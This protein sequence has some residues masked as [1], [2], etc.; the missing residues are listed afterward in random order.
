VPSPNS[1]RSQESKSRV[2]PAPLR[3]LGAL[4]VP[5]WAARRHGTGAGHAAQPS[6]SG[7]DGIPPGE[8]VRRYQGASPRHMMAPPCRCLCIKCPCTGAG[9]RV[10]GALER[11]GPRSRPE[12]T[13]ER[14]R[15]RSRGG[16]GTRARRSLLEGSAPPRTGRSPPE[17]GAHPRARR[18]L[19][20]G[21][22]E[23]AASCMVRRGV[24]SVWLSC[25][26]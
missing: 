26:F 4:A 13:L 1:A 14:G 16:A 24:F 12:R 25:G 18:S 10:R 21:I 9:A 5:E 23:W 2:Q 11:G 8:L 22:F 19:L 20:E 7:G 6:H 3:G 17:G 15:A